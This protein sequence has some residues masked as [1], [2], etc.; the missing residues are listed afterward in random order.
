MFGVRDIRTRAA[1][2][3]YTHDVIIILTVV[4]FAILSIDKPRMTDNY[5]NPLGIPPVMCFDDR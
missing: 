1:D 2:E 3:Q 5:N 4:L